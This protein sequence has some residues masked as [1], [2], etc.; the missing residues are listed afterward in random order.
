MQIAA[1]RAYPAT[2]VEGLTAMTGGVLLCPELSGRTVL[3]T[4]GLG[5][6]GRAQ[7]QAFVAS[8]ARLLLLDIPGHADADRV[9]AQLRAKGPGE[10][11]YLEQDLGDLEAARSHVLELVREVGGIDVL[12]NNAALIINR[13]FE[14]LSLAEYEQQMRV[15]SGAAF[16][17]AQAVAP[18]MKARG[19]GSIINFCSVTLSGEWAGFVPYVASKGALLGLTR[20]LARELGVYG[21]RVNAISPGAVVSEA[22]DR[23]FGDRAAEYQEWV[24]RH[25]CLQRRIQPEDIA[26][27][28]LFLAGDGSRMVSGHLLEVNGGW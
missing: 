6:L 22:E 1:R 13:P 5:S 23:V 17:L 27:A 8:G 12:V 7:A 10:V 19:R 28:V 25:Q 3:L 26:S 24:L 18:G 14:S 21:I 15:N 11:R 9:V 16:A 2:K 20:S 4:G